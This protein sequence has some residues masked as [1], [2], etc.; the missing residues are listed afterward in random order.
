MSEQQRGGQSPPPERSTGAQ[1]HS[2]PGSGKGL[3][4]ATSQEQM[5]KKTLKN[6]TSNPA[7]GPLDDAR[8]QKFAKTAS[9]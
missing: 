7:K 2:P 9:K 3:N 5:N 6:W 1:L 8:E 4:D